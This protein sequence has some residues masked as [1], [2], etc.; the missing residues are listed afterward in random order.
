[1]KKMCIL[2]SEVIF[3]LSNSFSSFSAINKLLPELEKF[4]RD[5]LAAEQLTEAAD[6]QRQEFLAKLGD[7]NTPPQLPP[8]GEKKKLSVASSID[9]TRFADL[10][11]SRDFISRQR[12]IS[13]IHKET[14]PAPAA[15][16]APYQSKR[17]L[18]AEEQEAVSLF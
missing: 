12:E 17:R 11:K 3:D 15:G 4:L 8:R 18:P 2:S 1:M 14:G 10:H 13:W 5:T 16:A 9:E 6:T 7:L